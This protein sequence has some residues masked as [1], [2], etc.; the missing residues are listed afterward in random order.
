MITRQPKMSA[1]ILAALCVFSCGTP[2][3]FLPPP[4][5]PTGPGPTRLFFPTG[6]AALPDG[7]L[8]VAN[9]NFNHAYDGGS[10][11]TIRKSYLDAFFAKK[12]ECQ[13][14]SPPESR[15]SSPNP[16]CVPGDARPV[17][18]CDDDVST[19][20]ADVFGGAVII[21][22][23]A[24]PLALN[25]SGT[26]AF[27][28]SRDTATLNAVT[29]NPDLTLTCAPGAGVSAIDCRKGIDLR[30]SGIIGPFGIVAGDA[31]D[32]SG[33]QRRVLYVSSMTPRVDEVISGGLL[34]SGV[35][36][37][38]DM[39]DPTQVLFTMLA[40]SRYVASGT[41]VGP[42]IFDPTRRQLLLSG[43]FQRF[44]GTGAGEPGTGRCGGTSNNF[45]RFLDVDAREA[46]S[47]Q[48]YDLFGDVFSIETTALLL[49]DP[50]PVTQIPAT[51]WATMRNPDILVQVELPPQPSVA[52][53]VRRV[54][55]LPVA[56]ADI[57]RIPRPGG[58]DLLAIVAEKIGAL[59][60][61]DTGTE[62]V[63]GQIENLGDSPFTARLLNT[64][65]GT[66][67]LAVSVFKGCKVALVEVP[68]AAP[69]KASLR[70]RVGTCP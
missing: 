34:T 10:L 44:P 42:M 67:Q 15:L 35:V 68:L 5:G 51:L 22:N 6:L 4:F 26:V 55:P 14:V 9:G 57:V 2:P 20:P 45:L 47:V 41:A 3:E 66:A 40:G 16:A 39:A 21:G 29:I 7:S 61:Y 25:D 58:A 23:Y 1:A 50:D 59:A 8:V 38:L 46:A 30:P 69:W 43:C 24:G 70:G 13:K 65:A 53:R 12:L 32:R 31:T 18:A 60:L 28:G 54:V 48:L 62:Q 37:A 36:A 64:S 52:P 19:H 33:A 27:T 56:P 63:V 11:V 49:A 17:C